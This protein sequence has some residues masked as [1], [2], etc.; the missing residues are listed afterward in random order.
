[1]L[2]QD[3]AQAVPSHSTTEWPIEH[4]I[5]KS[6]TK[7]VSNIRLITIHIVLNKRKTVAIWSIIEYG[8]KFIPGNA[9]ITKTFRFAKR[10]FPFFVISSNRKSNKANVRYSL[11]CK[12]WERKIESK[13]LS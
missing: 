13:N 6:V 2:S 10:Y 4:T 5:D 3:P 7:Y 9:D 1:M 12:N 11:Q 8:H